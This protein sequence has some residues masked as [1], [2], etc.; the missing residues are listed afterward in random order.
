MNT[1]YLNPVVIKQGA[2]STNIN[3]EKILS[4]QNAGETL[5]TATKWGQ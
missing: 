4:A 1:K 5:F 3:T 2:E